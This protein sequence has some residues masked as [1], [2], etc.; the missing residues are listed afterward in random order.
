MKIFRLLLFLIC[1]LTTVSLFAQHFRLGVQEQ[2]EQQT[3]TLSLKN[4]P[5]E[6][7]LSQIKKQTGITFVYTKD[8]LK[9]AGKVSVQAEK[10]DLQT[11]LKQLFHNTSINF[12]VFGNTVELST[13]KNANVSGNIQLNNSFFS[14]GIA[15]GFVYTTGGVRPNGASVIIKRSHLGTITNTNGALKGIASGVL[16]TPASGYS[17]A[18]L[19]VEIRGRNSIDPASVSDPLYIIDGVPLI[20]ANIGGVPSSN[21]RG[22]STGLQQAGISFSGG[23]LEKKRSDLYS[24]VQIELTRR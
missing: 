5:L 13:K 20:Q 14:K 23:V 7:V 19:K 18:P 21:Y 12:T 1:Q 10:A 11:V 17:N 9:I 15:H 4:V 24:E 3:I 6:T 22:G 8:I 16:I 2:P